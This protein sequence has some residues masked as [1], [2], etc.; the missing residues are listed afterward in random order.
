MTAAS[1]H[2]FV[3]VPAA[4]VYLRRDDQVLL[5]LRQNTGYMD[6][7]WAAAAAGHVEL[8]ETAS[9]TAR[10]EAD[11]ELGIALTDADLVPLTV[12][13]RTDG[14]ATPREQ[15]VDFF[16]TAHGWRGEPR[17]AEPHKCGALEWFAVD[18]LPPWMPPHE[19]FVLESLSNGGMPRFTAFGF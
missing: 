3:V 5:Q 17:I 19:R 15:R 16:F 13:Q 1:E 10:R 18:R 14:T 4:Y 8:G 6:D 9:A 7:T 11:E 12:M 2:S